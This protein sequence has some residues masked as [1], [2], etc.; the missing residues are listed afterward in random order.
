M[1]ILN[2][3]DKW[4]RRIGLWRGSIL[5]RKAFR[6]WQLDGSKDFKKRHRSAATCQDRQ[7]IPAG[8]L[9]KYNK[10]KFLASYG[11]VAQILQ[12]SLGVPCSHTPTAAF[13]AGFQRHHNQ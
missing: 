13:Q 7:Q 11:C 8:L 5:F 9:K 4:L 1:P 6:A 12:K 2:C 3:A 10:Y